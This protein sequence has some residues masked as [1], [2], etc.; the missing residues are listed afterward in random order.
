MTDLNTI[1][2]V[3]PGQ[4]IVFIDSRVQDVSALLKNFTP[5]VRLVFLDAEQDG[6]EQMAAALE[7]VTGLTALHVI[8]HGSQGQLNLGNSVVDSAALSRQ[9]QVLAKI[10][11]SLSD[12]GDIMLYGC[13][14]AA[15]AEGQSFIEALASATGADVAASTNVTGSSVLGGDWMLERATAVWCRHWACSL[16]QSSLIGST[17]WRPSLFQ[18]VA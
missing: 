12:D 15:G 11:A 4:E 10:G 17:C 3:A 13:N 9:A 14:V 18:A 8:S 6:L 2:P 1:S 5:H 16:R 7:G